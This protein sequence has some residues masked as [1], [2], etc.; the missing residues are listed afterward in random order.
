MSIFHDIP[1]GTEEWHLLRMGR[2]TASKFAPI[3][4]T[5]R[6]KGAEFSSGAITL[7]LDTAS[8]IL[9]NERREVFSTL[10]MEHGKNLEQA[11]REHYEVATFQKVRPG[12]F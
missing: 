6:E 11:A 7:L 4:V 9:T 12:G 5:P 3:M 8:E 2:I 10:A 1:Q